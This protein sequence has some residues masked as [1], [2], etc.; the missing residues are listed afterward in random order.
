MLKHS[1][2]HG[3]LLVNTNVMSTYA[4][5]TPLSVVL[6]RLKEKGYGREL[7]ITKTGAR[8]E[9]GEKTYGPEQL[10]IVKIYR[11]EGASDPADM[12][13]VYAIQAADG[14]RG[15]LLNAYGTYSDQ[16]NPFYDTFIKDVAVDEVDAI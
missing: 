11:F 15:F 7:T 14:E 3:V 2:H 5:M 12:A 13:I 1:P 10:T 4:T 6:T 8:L 16:D 9:G